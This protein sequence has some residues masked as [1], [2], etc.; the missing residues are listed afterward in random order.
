[1]KPIRLCLVAL[2]LLAITGSFLYGVDAK[3][4]TKPVLKI[5]V[6]LPLT[7][8]N[9]RAGEEMKNG[10]TLALEDLKDK[11]R[12]ALKVNFEDDQMENRQTN[13]AALRLMQLDHVD[14]IVSLWTPAA[15]L[16]GPR[17]DAQK[18]I[19][20]NTGWDTSVVEKYHW[21]ILHGGDLREFAR[22]SV[23]IMK[24][25]HVKRLAIAR[26][27]QLGFQKAFEAAKPL[28]KEAGI[29]IVFDEPF[30]PGT[31]DFR[32]YVLKI[33]ETKPDFLWNLSFSPEDEILFRAVSQMGV[34]WPTTGYFCYTSPEL[35]HYI[36]GSVFPY[37]FSQDAFN[38]KYR[39]HFG[40]TPQIAE[41]GTCYDI[42]NITSEA[43]NNLY[44]KL[45]RLPTHEELL[46]ELKRPRPLPNLAVGDAVMNA[47][48][49]VDSH[50]RL[51]EIKEDKIID[52]LPTK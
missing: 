28:I 29:E 21:T 34:S 50:Y 45:E 51:A 23:E 38:Q 43:V 11:N 36:N 30:P 33:H 16:I 39:S 48:G 32:T 27:E 15:N 46:A 49:Y 40:Q 7:G 25:R 26:V 37:F 12:V 22:Q 3:T 1:M 14:M 44:S 19:Q 4:P 9:A 2:L 31:R 17:T 6:V 35:Y 20:F 52:Y 8:N 5:G 47:Q 41:A 24:I 18:V 10:I 42:I 13:L